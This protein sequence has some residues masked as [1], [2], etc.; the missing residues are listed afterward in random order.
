[1]V[2]KTDVAPALRLASGRQQLTSQPV[3]LLMLARALL[4]KG[5]Q[6]WAWTAIVRTLPWGHMGLWSLTEPDLRALGTHRGWKPL[7]AEGSG[8][9]VGEGDQDG[10]TGPFQSRVPGL[11]G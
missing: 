7:G 6:C 8:M 4:W 5:E 10:L 3:S 1:M 11:R 2:N 9:E